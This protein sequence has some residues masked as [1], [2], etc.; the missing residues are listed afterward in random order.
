[1]VS[2][3]SSFYII[4]NYRHIFSSLI[5]P[6]S[7]I[8]PYWVLRFLEMWC[9]LMG[10]F[11]GTGWQLVSIPWF[12]FPPDVLLMTEI[13]SVVFFLRLPVKHGQLRKVLRKWSLQWLT[14]GPNM[15]HRLLARSVDVFYTRKDS[16]LSSF[17]RLGEGLH[18][19]FQ[20]EH[21]ENHEALGLLGPLDDTDE[22]GAFDLKEE[23]SSHSARDP[24]DPQAPNCDGE[25]LDW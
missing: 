2:H 13:W 25:V 14:T 19:F 8:W 24:R 11:Q 12:L 7:G 10:S 5:V 20:A 23:V 15:F 3:H 17:F 4:V 18:A 22:I 1:M 16:I 6:T 21:R 9:S